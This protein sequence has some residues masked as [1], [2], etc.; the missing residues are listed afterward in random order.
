MSGAEPALDALLRALDERPDAMP[1]LVG[2]TASGKTA[3]ALALAR[4]TGGEIVGADSVQVYRGFDIGSGKPTAEELANST[5]HLIDVAEPDEPIDAAAYVALADAAIAEVRARGRVAIVC[6]GTFL[7]VKALLHGLSEAPGADPELRAR[8]RALVEAEGPLALHSRLAAVDP[9]A[10]ARLHPNDLVRTSRA[11]EVHE[12]SGRRLSELQ[13][14]HGFGE[15]R[16]PA[17]LLAVS[18]TPDE[19]DQR[20]RAR[21]RTWLEGGFV[22]EVRSLCARG[23]HDA[24]AM[25]SVGY[26]QV[27]DFLDGAIP[28]EQL[29]DAIVR[30]TRT[31]ARRQRTWLKRAE[32]SWI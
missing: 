6:G 28:E 8:H 19:L 14:A 11:L 20:I 13:E 18:R 24:R 3:L 12:L 25:T 27:R 5:H 32:V 2:P 23:F 7:W 4:R 10:A 9:V 31:F 15:R 21:V 17:L 1:C 30:A 29:E 22:E 26:R 16:H